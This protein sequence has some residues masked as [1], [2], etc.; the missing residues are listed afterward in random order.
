M[1]TE[2]T[3]S[4]LE[5]Q[6][7][8][9]CAGYT[10]VD[11]CEDN[12]ELAYNINT[13]GCYNLALIAKKLDCILV[14]MS[15]DYVFNGKKDEPYIE[16]DQPNPINIYGNSK[17]L[18]EI[19]VSKMCLKHFILRTSWLYGTTGKN[20]VKTILRIADIKNKISVVNDQIG[21]PTYTVDLINIIAQLINTD[22]Y[23]TYHVS[24]DGQCSWY[25]FANK[26]IQLTNK[27]T[28]VVPITTD[29]LKR[30]ANRP[31]YSVLKN[32]MLEYQFNYNL[33]NWQDALG[34]FLNKDME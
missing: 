2:R 9:N 25:E 19:I 7:I 27:N 4:K 10:N 23:G 17:L 32:Y 31:S 8:I 18:G 33:R 30:T 5:P 28:S 34:E 22:A 11:D 13:Q 26:I 21:T 24:N 20:F 16:S 15:T 1:D 3:I 29:Q 6:A 12:Y 14:H